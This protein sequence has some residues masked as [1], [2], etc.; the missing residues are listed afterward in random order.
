MPFVVKVPSKV[1]RVMNI[2]ACPPHDETHET[3]DFP[4]F[5]DLCYYPELYPQIFETIDGVSI[6][7]QQALRGHLV[8]CADC[9]GKLGSI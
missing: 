3:N 5:Y 9:S 2:E 1:A 8:L 6:W 4:I 7:L